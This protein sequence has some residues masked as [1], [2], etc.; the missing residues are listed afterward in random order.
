MMKRFWAHQVFVS[1]ALLAGAWALAAME[2]PMIGEE[3]PAFELPTLDGETLSS[4]DLRGGYVVL[5]F[6]AGW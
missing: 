1:V 2:H 3:A 5:H 4:S 6:G